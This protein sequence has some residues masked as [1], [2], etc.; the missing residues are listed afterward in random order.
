MRQRGKPLLTAA[1]TLSLLV[2]GIWTLSLPSLATPAAASPLALTVTGDTDQ[3]I[4]DSPDPDIVRVGSTLYLFTTG[5]TWGNQIGVAQSS[6][7]P[8]SSW[9]DLHSAFPAVPY[10]ESLAPWEEPETT[11]SPGVF[12]YDGKWIMYYDANDTAHNDL[13][14]LSVATASSVTGPYTDSSTGPIECQTTLGGSLDPQPFVDP[15]TGDPSLIWKSNDGSSSAASQI[16]SQP[17]GSNG[18]SLTGSPTAIFTIHSATYPWQTTTDDPSMAYAGGSFYLF[19][20]GGNYLSS[21]YPTGYVVCSGPSGGCDLNEA[22][23]PILS[24]TGGAGG[25]MVFSDANGNWWLAS[26]TWEPTTCTHYVS[27]GSCVRELFLS[28]ISLPPV[29]SPEIATSSIPTAGVGVPYS[30]TLATSAGVAPFTWSITAGTLPNGLAL[31]ASTGTISGTATS[32][33]TSPVTIEVTDADHQ[34]A[35]AQF[36]VIVGEGTMTTASA[37]LPSTTFGAP[38]TYSASVTSTPTGDNP[39]SE[40]SVIF[41][42]DGTALCTASL[43]GAD[44][45]CTTTTT[46][47]GADTVSATFSGDADFGTSVGTT[48]IVVTSGPYSP[49]TPVRICDTR[50]GN[51]S[52]L[53]G[54]AAQC[55]GNSIGAG[56]TRTINVAGEFG[57]PSDATATVFNVTAVDPSGSG[58][59]IVF[60]AGATQPLASSLNY[61]AGEVVPNLVEVGIGTSGEVSI[62]S[63]SRTDVVVDL[64]GYVAPTAAGGVGAGLYNALPSPAR[65]CDTRVGNPSHLTGADTQCDGLRLSAA[66][67]LPVQVATLNG[68]PTDATAAVL[69]VTV[70]NPAAAGFLTIYPEDASLPTTANVNYTAGQTTGNRVIVPL[71]S[72]GAKL[73]SIDV[74]SKAAADIVVDVSGYFSASGGGGS[75]FSAEPAPVRIC[76]TR[77]ANPSHLSGA[78]AQCL[79]RPIGAGQANVLSVNVTGLAGV[80]A[81]AIAVVIN[82]TAVSP[83]LNTDLTVYPGGNVPLTSDL[84]PAAGQV[85][86][87]LTVATISSSGTISIYNNSGSVN[88]VVDVLGWYS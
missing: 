37:N 20:S 75:Q 53:T 14:C 35:S 26:Q 71:S 61:A 50:A 36:E 9:E 86:G 21:Y 81:N 22:N 44:A 51:P 46:P 49:L 60:P 12:N 7:P 34:T 76:D 16:W 3:G 62:S 27:N 13:T 8:H 15:V 79:N 43:V 41:S 54:D 58:Q 4:G 28:S 72:T 68:I 38:V 25:G 23:D 87:N 66:G 48:S 55:N 74:Y 1:A 40:G 70:V 29:P 39:N 17:I 78:A 88:V 45:T 5:T 84:N 42:V 30:F 6:D 18:V 59:L 31:H 19:F 32:E 47:V 82:L 11:T 64:E 69:N 24:E 77:P 83:T 80:P 52:D 65:L 10:N 56:G 73:G 33:G 57:V 85:K 63:L 67:T 2:G